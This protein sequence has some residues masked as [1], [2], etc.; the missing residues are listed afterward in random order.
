MLLNHLQLLTASS[1]FSTGSMRHTA[2]SQPS[3]GKPQ[4]HITAPEV[5]LPCV[6]IIESAT[7]GSVPRGTGKLITLAV[8]AIIPCEL[9][10]L[11]PP[12][13]RW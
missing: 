1:P 8:F 10:Q 3:S 9:I 12:E 2:I 5:H 11:I 13:S 4:E 7:R 6:A